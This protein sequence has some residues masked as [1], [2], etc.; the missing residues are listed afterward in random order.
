[1][2]CIVQVKKREERGGEPTEGHFCQVAVMSIASTK[3]L[4]HV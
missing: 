4:P 1:M 3:G 2:V